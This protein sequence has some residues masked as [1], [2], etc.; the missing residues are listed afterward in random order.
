M[1]KN[2]ME[3]TGAPLLRCGWI[4]I[5]KM[6]NLVVC[7]GDQYTVKIKSINNPI[8]AIEIRINWMYPTTLLI[9]PLD[10]IKCFMDMIYKTIAKIPANDA[11]LFRILRLSLVVE[12]IGILT[13]GIITANIATKREAPNLFLPVLIN[14]NEAINEITN[15][16]PKPI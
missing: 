8:T 6:K 11:V 13:K 10:F 7:L 16:S 15:I 14:R 5:I 9:F 4:T 2:E 3:I 12:K 1:L